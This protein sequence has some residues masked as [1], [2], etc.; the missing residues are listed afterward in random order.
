LLDSQRA[1]II[2]KDNTTPLRLLKLKCHGCGVIGAGKNFWDLCTP[3]D[4]E[5]A[6]RFLL[7]QDIGRKVVL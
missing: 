5:E 6:A 3:F 1:S 7:G 2:R 4:R